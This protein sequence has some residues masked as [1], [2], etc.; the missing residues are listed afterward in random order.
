MYALE[1]YIFPFEG[2]SLV[3]FFRFH[4]DTSENFTF[5]TGSNSKAV[6][7]GSDGNTS[8][9]HTPNRLIAVASGIVRQRCSQEGSY[10]STYIAVENN[11]GKKIIYAH[12]NK[13][14]AP[15]SGT[16]LSQGQYIG[17]LKISSFSDGVCGHATQGSSEFH[18]H[19]EVPNTSSLNF[20]RLD[21]KHIYRH[22]D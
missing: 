17:T 8:L 18:V 16:S 22:L 11:D 3:K 10:S 4:F 1:T 6:D 5:W 21:F 15:Q 13:S 12:L 2:G 19:F 7:I 14:D 9:N 20:E